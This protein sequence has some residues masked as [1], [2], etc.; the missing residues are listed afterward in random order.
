MDGIEMS[1]RI[2][3]D[4]EQVCDDIETILGDI[5]SLRSERTFSQA[6]GAGAGQKLRE[7]ETAIKKRLNDK[8]SLVV[9]GDFKRGKTSLINAILG[10]E[11]LPAAVTPETVTI[12][13]LSYS[14]TPKAEAVLQ[15]GKRAALDYTELKRD[16]LERL[17]PNLP[18]PIDCIDVRADNEMLKEISVVDTP[19][20]GDLMNEFD[21]KVAEYMA[22]ADALVYVVSARAPFSV[23]EQTFLASTV[24]PQSFSQIMVVVNMAD[25]LETDEN[26]EKIKALTIERARSIGD[27]VTVFMLSSLDELCRK[28]G[29]KRPEPDLENTL[30]NNFL[31]FE[32]A[33]NRDIIMQKDII[34]SMRGVALTGMM[35]RDVSARIELVKNAINMGIENL[36]SNVEDF[37]NQDSELRKK[38][39][40][41]KDELASEIDEMKNEAKRW[42]SEFMSRLRAEMETIKTSAAMADI[43]R[44]FQFYVMD[45]IKS[46]V[47][48]CVIHHQQEIANRTSKTIK[49]MASET[50]EQVFGSIDTNVAD[51]ITDVSWTGVDT[52]MFS[53][54]MADQ[55]LGISGQLGPLY[56]VGQAVMGFVRQ[57]KV[58][59]KQTDFIAPVLQEFDTI[60]SDVAGSVTK[61]YDHLKFS[62]VDILDEVYQKQAEA[63]VSAVTQAKEIMK[64]ETAK[65]EDVIHYLDGVLEKIG[66]LKQMLDKY[67]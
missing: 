30:E 35:L 54:D 12:N 18:A 41:H 34:K 56:L 8:F 14:E 19:G 55:F 62:A 5:R 38:I 32:Y 42:I 57:K 6:L 17:L 9:V 20:V 46:A 31:E 66:E 11:L 33:L 16:I 1:D 50:T 3:L 22:N 59:G 40:R 39:D 2:T 29:K 25:I 15:N 26:I 13:R 52:A 21:E 64:D 58:S 48:A 24:V 43:E 4:F 67:E 23:S 49:D 7:H 27:N 44:H 36:S 28:K 47:S 61:V 51:C 45:T 65:K 53:F 60:A 63:S 10:E 37:Q